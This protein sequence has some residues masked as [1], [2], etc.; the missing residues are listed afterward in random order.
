MTDT[1]SIDGRPIGPNNPPY[2]IAEISGNHNGEIERALQLIDAAKTAGADA[3]KFQ[4]YTADTITIDH[5]GPGFIIEGG[6][7][8]GRSLHDL[9]HEAHTPWHWHPTLFEHAN[10]IGITAFSS[11]FDLMAVDLLEGLKA[12]AYKIASFEIVDIPLIKYVAKTGKPLIISTGMASENDISEAIETVRQTA[13]ADPV[14]LHCISGYPTPAEE[15]NLPRMASLRGTFGCMTGLSDHTLGNATAIAATA[16]GAV[17]IEKHF[18]LDRA[19]GGPDAKFSLNPRELNSLI[20][21]VKDAY[22]A[23][24]ISKNEIADS[25]QLNTGLR[26]SLYVVADIAEGE[27]FTPENIRSIRP[28]HGL[29][30]KYLDKI[31]QCQASRP[32]KRGMPVSENDILPHLDITP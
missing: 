2:V 10:K 16:L 6:V 32:L 14:L 4:T 3:V 26:R 15:A 29:A 31:L 23:S 28:G 25:E 9:Y 21:D 30:P 27:K 22:A 17:I 24:R 19:D 5:D 1:F 11:P 20:R 8:D 18:T 12:P 7:W 13:T